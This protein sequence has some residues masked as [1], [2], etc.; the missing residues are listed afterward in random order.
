MR[1]GNREFSKKEIVLIQETVELFPSLSRKEIARTICENLNWKNEANNLKI[2]SCLNLLNKLH[3]IGKIK[4]PPLRITNKVHTIEKK[5]LYDISNKIDIQSSVE[6]HNVYLKL[7]SEPEDIDNWN[8]LVNRYHYLGYKKNFGL[9]LKYFIF[10]EELENPIGCMSYE[11]SSTYQLKC[12]DDLIGWNKKQ[13]ES[14]LNWIINNNRFLIF[15]WVNIT[16]LASKA[17][18]LAF[19]RLPD[20]WFFKFNYK[21]VLLE[22]YVDSSK[23][24]GTIYKASNWQKIGQTSGIYSRKNNQ[25]LLP[26]NV[27]IKPIVKNY[28]DVLLD[29]PQPI[30]TNSSKNNMQKCIDTLL[31]NQRELNLWETIQLKIALICKKID[32]N[33]MGHNRKINALTMLLAIYRI[34]YTKNFESYSSVLCELLD[35]ANNYGI[36]LSFEDTISASS[37]CYARKNF[38]AKAF[39]KIGQ[40]IIELYEQKID[41]QNEYLWKGRRVFA[42]DGSKVN[43]PRKTI[44]DKHGGYK[45]PCSHAFYPQGLISCLYRLKSRVA[46]D[47]SLV[48]TM[49]EQ[50]EAIKHLKS[51]KTEDVVVYDRGYI[52]YPLL[53]KHKEYGI[54]A[55]F[56]LK[57]QSFKIIDNFIKNNSKD[58]ITDIVPSQ[59]S[60]SKIKN[61]YNFIKDRKSFKMRLMKYKIKDK[62]YYLGTTILDNEITIQ[63]YVQI[64]HARWGHEEFYKSLKHQLKAIEFHGKTETFIQQEIYAGFNIM[65]LNRIMSNNIE[66]KFIENNEEDLPDPFQRKRKVNFKQQMDELYRTVEA[67]IA[68]DSKTQKEEIAKST[69]RSK[70]QS[71]KTRKDRAYPRKSNRHVNK[72]QRL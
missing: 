28:I 10:I 4:L 18:H 15:P 27:Y 23:F 20:D 44:E 40:E 12:R 7:I 64:Y 66:E 31:L 1:V 45:L 33:E 62:E 25:R 68:G 34:T 37:F 71:Y 50:Q 51:L 17:L 19:L 14:K 3:E 35:N 58:I 41:K 65:T 8:D 59:K 49:N 42:V 72:W 38:P 6:N 47:Y 63:D 39:K 9:H 26:K 11:A 32:E 48:N 56:R 46:Y 70:R 55:I 57:K 61:K 5:K 21:P 60:Y 54:D 53:Y 29:H 30:Q 24:N 16:N 13:R 22:T 2:I 69:L 52:S 36:K 43:L 67:V